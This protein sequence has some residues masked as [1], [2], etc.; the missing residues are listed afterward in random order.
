MKKVFLLLLIFL[1]SQ[2]ANAE[3][4]YFYV[5]SSMTKPAN[6]LVNKFNSQSSSFKV[7]LITGGSG[8]LLN[9]ILLSRRADIYVPASQ[10]FLNKAKN[11]GI[12]LQVKDLLYQ[13]PVFGI[14]KKAENKIKNFDDLTNK[15]LQIALG[16]KNTMAL[17]KI[18]LE[19]EAKLP[20]N[21]KNQIRK[22]MKVEAINISQIVNYLKTNVVDAGILFDSTARVNNLKYVKIPDKFN[23]KIKVSVAL[24][25]LSNDEKKSKLFFEFIFKNKDIFKKFG[26]DVID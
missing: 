24:L 19:I 9:K 3:E 21:L 16:K 2:Y 23:K 1:L 18:F 13:T 5:A 22:N 7:V 17:G 8:Q 14:A 4:I 10:F 11:K 20:E 26:F 25:N 15:N 12:V 6:I